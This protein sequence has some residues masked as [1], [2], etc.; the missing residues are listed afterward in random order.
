MVCFL[1]IPP[2]LV[3]N[4]SMGRVVHLAVASGLAIRQAVV[5]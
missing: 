3:F 2:N 5:P 1:K 4:S